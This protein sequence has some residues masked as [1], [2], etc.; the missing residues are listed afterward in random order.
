MAKATL[1]RREFLQLAKVYNPDNLKIG[2]GGYFISEKLDGSRCFWD[3]GISR[4]MYTNAVPYASITNPKTGLRKAKIKPVATGLWSRYG[5]PIMAPEWF[6]DS[7]PATMLDG[8]LFA[9]RGKFQLC[10][11]IC[12]GDRPDPRFDQITFA[13]YSAPPLGRMFLPGEI[14][15]TNFHCMLSASVLQW[16]RQQMPGGFV[17][18][19]EGS[20]FADEYRW[21]QEVL[22]GSKHAVAHRQFT[23]ASDDEHA[24]EE[25]E[26]YIEEVLGKG[27]E[28]VIIRDPKAVWTP[29]RVNALLKHKPY[30]DSEGIITG[31]TSGRKTDKGSKHL[32]KIGAL[33]LSVDTLVARG[34]RLELSGLTDEERLFETRDMSEVAS[35]HPGEDMSA[36]FQGKHF[37]VGQTV[38]FKYRELS[39]AGVPKEARFWRK[40]DVE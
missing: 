39:D 18:L 26:E 23:L 12:A 8:E 34:K 27:G 21:L 25:I 9:G 31:F 11:S 28:G 38:T 10:R 14:K 30:F 4:G 32:G 15:N 13:C 35:R 6:L 36:S 1:P 22:N 7:L 24:R 17:S 33:I 16:V 19:D 3:G 2:V 40:R 37:K 29:K 5:N 20:T